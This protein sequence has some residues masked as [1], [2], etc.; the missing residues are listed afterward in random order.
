MPDDQ[1]LQEIMSNSN[2]KRITHVLFRR[3]MEN[4][5][6]LTTLATDLQAKLNGF[7]LFGQEDLEQVLLKTDKDLFC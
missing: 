7:K 4:P 2:L 5:Y 6:L 3:K 1:F